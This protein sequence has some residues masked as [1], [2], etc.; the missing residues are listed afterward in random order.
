VLEIV[1]ASAGSDRLKPGERIVESKGAARLNLARASVREALT[2]LAADSHGLISQSAIQVSQLAPQ[3]AS[4]GNLL[5]QNV[6]SPAAQ[7]AGI[8]ISYP[9]F[10]GP[11]SQV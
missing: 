11:V 1:V 8:K 10:T 5:L 3:Y 4:V 7:A 2:I 6:N 9:G